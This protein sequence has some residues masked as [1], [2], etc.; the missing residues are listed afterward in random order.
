M[1]QTTP[2][3]ASQWPIHL[4]NFKG[5]RSDSGVRASWE[6]ICWLVSVVVKKRKLDVWVR[7]PLIR[8]IETKSAG[9]EGRPNPHR[10]A[11]TWRRS[12]RWNRRRTITSSI[13]TLRPPLHFQQPNFQPVYGSQYHIF[14]LPWVHPH[15]ECSKHIQN[16][17]F[18]WHL[19]CSTVPVA[20]AQI[21]GVTPVQIAVFGD[22]F[23][24]LE[25][26]Y[27]PWTT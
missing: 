3:L 14:N 22:S 5:P 27:V 15:S 7:F 21:N 24:N 6:P 13:C 9:P 12:G 20:W 23:A 11:R 8:S 2:P 19:W 10:D 26:K 4:F 17:M 1:N 16:T 18:G 25:I